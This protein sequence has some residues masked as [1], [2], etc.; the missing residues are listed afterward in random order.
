MRHRLLHHA[1][2]ATGCMRGGAKRRESAGEEG[3]GNLSGED[4]RDELLYNNSTQQ[5]ITQVTYRVQSTRFEL[6]SS[7][8]SSKT[9]FIGWRVEIGPEIMQRRSTSRLSAHLL[10]SGGHFGHRIETSP[11][12]GLGNL[13]QGRLSPRGIHAE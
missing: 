7:T 8:I 3:H 2:F 11:P 10:C 13:P 12:A 1:H 4:H 6:G 9:F 5:V